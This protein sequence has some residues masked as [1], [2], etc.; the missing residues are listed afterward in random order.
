MDPYNPISK[1][2][3]NYYA[4]NYRPQLEGES[5]EIELRL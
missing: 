4:N 5:N 2:R 1:L 3:S